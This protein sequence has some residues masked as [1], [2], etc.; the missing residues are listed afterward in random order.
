MD[1]LVGAV[2]EVPETIQRRQIGHLMQADT[3]YGRAVAEGLGFDVGMAE[4]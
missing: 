3:E 2:A 1:N 4:V